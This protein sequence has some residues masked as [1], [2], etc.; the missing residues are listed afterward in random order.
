[1]LL[2]PVWMIVDLK[3]PC[4]FKT[5]ACQALYRPILDFSLTTT[6]ELKLPFRDG[7]LL[8]ASA[9]AVPGRCSLEATSTPG[10]LGGLLALSVFAVGV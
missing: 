8:V 10:S 3:I 7:L 6:S 1:M 5:F 4:R 2:L 9:L